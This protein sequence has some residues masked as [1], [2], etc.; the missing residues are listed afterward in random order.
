[1]N[2]DQVVMATL[3]AE[4]HSVRELVR[5]MYMTCKDDGFKNVLADVEGKLIVI[6]GH[7]EAGMGRVGD[8]K[9]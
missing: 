6:E 4:A 5:Y 2:G 9:E 8:A 3:Y 1:M 7:F